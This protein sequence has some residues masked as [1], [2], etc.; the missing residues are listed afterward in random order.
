MGI[1]LKWTYL[2]A[3]LCVNLYI[4]VYI[5]I[6]VYSVYICVFIC[7]LMCF[8]IFVY[9]LCVYLYMMCVHHRGAAQLTEDKIRTCRRHLDHNE[10]SAAVYN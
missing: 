7:I 3:Y 9:I 1:F 5:C 8:C 2:C 10:Q 4:S 6:F